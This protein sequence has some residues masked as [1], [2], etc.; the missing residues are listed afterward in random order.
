MTLSITQ[1]EHIAQLARLELT[2]E[3]KKRYRLQLSTILEYA[4]RV[5]ALDTGGILPTDRASGGHHCLRPDEPQVGM[6]QMDLF[7]NAPHMEQNQFRVPPV[8]E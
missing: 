4:A 1:V 6:D 7:R 2:E 8:L 5:Q 3:E